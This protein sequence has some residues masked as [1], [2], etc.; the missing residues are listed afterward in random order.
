MKKLLLVKLMLQE[1][2]GPD[3]YNSKANSVLNCASG[4][5]LIVAILFYFL[6]L[7]FKRYSKVLGKQESFPRCSCNHN[8][9]NAQLQ[10]TKFSIKI[11]LY[12]LLFN[13]FWPCLCSV[14]FSQY[15]LCEFLTFLM[16][17]LK[18]VVSNH[19]H[20]SLQSEDCLLAGLLFVWLVVG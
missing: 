18:I 4:I 14:S 13:L 2:R 8:F 16:A 17:K 11:F 6:N 3:L 7:E 20:C 1:A 10:T 19:L 5:I 9:A 15:T 12:Q